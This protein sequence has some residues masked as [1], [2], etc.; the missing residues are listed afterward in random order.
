MPRK[1]PKACRSRGCRHTTIDR[2]GY[3]S[4]HKSSG[5][6]RYTRGKTAE[7]R[8]Y[9]PE[10]RKLRNIV[11]KRDKGLCQPCKREGVIRPGSSVDHIIAKAH[12]GT[13]DPSNLEC[14]C[15]DHHKTKTARERFSL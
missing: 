5:W 9:G 1:I 11:I 3:C 12:G 7:Q 15:T 14:I 2:D 13:D 10:W 8:G 6:E 4:D